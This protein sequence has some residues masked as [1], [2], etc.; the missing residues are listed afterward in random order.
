[1]HQPVALAAYPQAFYWPSLI[2]HGKWTWQPV[3]KNLVELHDC[4]LHAMTHYC[5]CAPLFKRPAKCRSKLSLW[6][7]S[8]LHMYTHSC[9]QPREKDMLTKPP[10]HHTPRQQRC[11]LMTSM[12]HQARLPAAVAQLHNLRVSCRQLLL[13]GSLPATRLCQLLLQAPDHA[14]ST[15]QLCLQ[16]LLLL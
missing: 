11:H 10:L 3:L 13:Q 2:D 6:G 8:R 15:C 4:G 1:M 9:R 14:L 5:G 12:L 16:R 7:L